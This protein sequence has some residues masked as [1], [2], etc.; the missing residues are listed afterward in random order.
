MAVVGLSLCCSKM[1]F[2]PYQKWAVTDSLPPFLLAS[3]RSVQPLRWQTIAKASCVWINL[4]KCNLE[5]FEEKKFL[6]IKT[7]NV[8]G[9]K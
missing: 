4:L 5:A 7:R 6:R 8:S 2:S 9:V 3:T 1:D